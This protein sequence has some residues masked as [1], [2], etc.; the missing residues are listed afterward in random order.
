MLF[1]EMSGSFGDGVGLLL[2]G[3]LYLGVLSTAFDDLVGRVGLRACLLTKVALAVQ[4]LF[5]CIGIS[6][7]V[8]LI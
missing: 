7:S 5:A 8:T 1:F 3:S 2:L 6:Q 4:V